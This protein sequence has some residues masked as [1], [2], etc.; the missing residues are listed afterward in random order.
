MKLY[1]PEP[2][3]FGDLFHEATPVFSLDGVVS[4]QLHVVVIVQVGH[5]HVMSSHDT[6]EVMLLSNNK[7]FV[8][9]V[10]NCEAVCLH[11][12][13]SGNDD[14]LYLCEAAVFT[15]SRVA[16]TTYSNFVS[17]DQVLGDIYADSYVAL[18]NLSDDTVTANSQT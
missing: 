15:L 10:V 11:T 16:M 8:F 4:V 3:I 13:Q 18:V 5:F 17:C 6:T 14:L 2:Y 12:E 9:C 1:V 7:M